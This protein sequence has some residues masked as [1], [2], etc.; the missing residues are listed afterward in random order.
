MWTNGDELMV[1]TNGELM[2]R[3]DD[4]DDGDDSRPRWINGKIRD[5]IFLISHYFWFLKL[6]T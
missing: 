3:N 4:D 2:V 1:R 6:I 5:G